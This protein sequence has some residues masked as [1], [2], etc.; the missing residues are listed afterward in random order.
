MN[1]TI[2]GGTGS[3][4]AQVALNSGEACVAEGGAMIALRGGIQIETST[5]QRGKGGVMRGIRR[6]LAGESFFINTFTAER[7]GGEV[8]LAPTLA[9]DMT[10]IEL[11]GVGVVAEAG[12]FMVCGTDVSIDVGW[13]GVKSIF[14]GEGLFWINCRGHGPLVLNGFGAI[15]SIDV[16]GEYI[17]DSGHIIAFEETLDF[18]ISKAG[19]SWITSFIGGEG[20]I[21][22]FKGRGRLWCQSHSSNAFGGLL[23][24][25]LKPR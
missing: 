19:Q 23:G 18:S 3:S 25:L 12:S 14:S 2:G 1:I 8:W 22:R 20:F 5:F 11:N 24:P 10:T 16:D 17:V 4:V 6:M 15:Y 13:Q 21:C 7:G 9:G